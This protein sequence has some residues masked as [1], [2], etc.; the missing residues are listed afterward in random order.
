MY[1]RCG[2][3]N[4][5][6]E[7]M[8]ISGTVLVAFGLVFSFAG[9]FLD[10]RVTSQHDKIEIEKRQTS[11]QIKLIEVMDNPLRIDVMNIGLDA[12]LIKKLYID[13]IADESYLLSDRYGDAL[14]DFPMNEL[15]TITPSIPGN[16]VKI[17]TEN[18]K[19][20]SFE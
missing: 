19:I 12:I 1:G 14:L 5:I 20:F 7:W 17:I 15:V 13:G 4:Q 16:N 18:N 2:N 6:I 9:D 3:M 8:A 11:E 10:D